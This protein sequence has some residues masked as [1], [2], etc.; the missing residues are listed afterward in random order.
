MGPLK[1]K[2][3]KVRTSEIFHFRTKKQNIYL[4]W[5]RTKLGKHT[6]SGA[7]TISHR[8]RVK[9][10]FFLSPYSNKSLRLCL[11]LCTGCICVGET[12]SSCIF[13]YIYFFFFPGRQVAALFANKA[14]GWEERNLV[15]SVEITTAPSPTWS[16]YLIGVIIKL[17]TTE[18]R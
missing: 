16:E 11:C 6:V 18:R 8:P 15:Y 17:G 4:L 12:A 2:H 9:C 3:F 5:G 14:E 13:I 10:W 7:A 1:E